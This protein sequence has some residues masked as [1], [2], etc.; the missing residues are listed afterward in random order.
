MIDEID[1]FPRRD[2]YKKKPLGEEWG[3]LKKIRTAPNKKPSNP[4]EPKVSKPPRPPGKE[5]K[6]R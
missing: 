6:S 2:K 3:E 4:A 5:E 1:Y